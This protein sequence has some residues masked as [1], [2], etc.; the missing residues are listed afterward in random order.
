MGEV[1]S[2][3]GATPQ[4]ESP[5]E[6]KQ[7]PF[8]HLAVVRLGPLRPHWLTSTT[9][10]ERLFLL[11]SVTVDQRVEY[12]GVVADWPALQN[13]LTTLV[14]DLFPQAKLVPVHENE[15]SPPE[16]TMTTL[17]VRLDTGEDPACVN[18]GW[19]PLR[20]GLVIAWAAAVLAIV[21][22]AIGGRAVLVTS[23]RRVRFAS[24]VTHELRTPLT[25]LQLH[26]DLLNSGLIT[27]EAKKAEYLATLAAEADRLN[28]LVENVLD[29]ARLEKPAAVANARPVPV[30]DLLDATRHTWADRLR[31]EEFDLIVDSTTPPGQTIVADPR[32]MEQ[33]LG[34][35][36]DNARKYAKSA[37]DRRI[38]VRALPAARGRVAV[39]VEDRGPGVP[40]NERRAIFRPFIRG[41]GTTDTGG[42]GLGLNL[43]REWAE[44]F[45]GSLVYRPATGGSGACFR[46]ELPG[47]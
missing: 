44:L 3:E 26:L 47:G 19:T 28:R 39:E 40:A 34:N 33:V 15:E 31:S 22:T 16:R 10:I 41:S 37:T 12:Q 7:P 11:R 24:A 2:G 9:G 4:A 43:A 42:A 18:C 27:D 29:F 46:L 13:T 45:G 17:P 38:W 30:D 20:F 6:P 23:G 8:D 5:A 1:K 36:I 25:A 21:A 32:V 14:T 35:L